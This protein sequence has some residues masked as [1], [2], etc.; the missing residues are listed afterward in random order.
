MP[1]Q[2]PA[3][4]VH[5]VSDTAHLLAAGAWVGALPAL[6]LLLHQTR[7]K[8]GNAGTAVRRLSTIGIASVGTLVATGFVNS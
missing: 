1:A 3:L 6:A 5:L 2:R 4:R 7:G 8:T